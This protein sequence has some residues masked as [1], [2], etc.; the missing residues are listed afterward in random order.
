[1]RREKPSFLIKTEKDLFASSN[2]NLETLSLPLPLPLS[3]FGLKL[4]KRERVTALASKML[5]FLSTRR[6]TH[7]WCVVVNTGTLHW[8]QLFGET[9]VLFSPH[10]FS[11]H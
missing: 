5:P 10:L 6:Y 8:A 9:L 3:P 7:N 4:M 2:I 1:M 11:G